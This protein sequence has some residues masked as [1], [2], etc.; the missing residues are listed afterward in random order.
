[1]GLGRLLDSEAGV[2]HPALAQHMHAGDGRGLLACLHA[3][4]TWDPRPWAT[5]FETNGVSATQRRELRS[6]LV[7]VRCCVLLTD[8]FGAL[9]FF[10]RPP[11]G[12]SCAALRRRQDSA[13]SFLSLTLLES[14]RRKVIPLLA[15]H[16][17]TLT[18]PHFV[19]WENVH[20]EMHL[21]LQAGLAAWCLH[22]GLTST[23]SAEKLLS[24]GGYN[25][26]L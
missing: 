20:R 21:A 13:L 3:A 9:L 22:R 11:P 14:K 8:L 10:L 7:Q 4:K 2:S 6:F 1:M 5:I 25:T 19:R 12:V 16:A 18:V 17:S 26:D 23:D 15:Q 24:R